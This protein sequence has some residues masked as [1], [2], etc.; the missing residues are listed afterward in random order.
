MRERPNELAE[1]FATAWDEGPKW[2]DK[3]DDGMAQLATAAGEV[4]RS[5]VRRWSASRRGRDW[6]PADPPDWLAA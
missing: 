4:L 6:R 1:A 2:R 5:E 3:L